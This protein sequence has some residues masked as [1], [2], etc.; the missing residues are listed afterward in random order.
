MREQ[1]IAHS[2]KLRYPLARRVVLCSFLGIGCLASVALG[3]EQ[4]VYPSADGTIVDGGGFGPFDGA[5]D[6]ADWIFN[7]TNYEGAITLARAPSP[8]L[9]RRVVCEYNLN[10]LTVRSPVVA[11]LTI[12]VRGS[13]LFPALTAGMQV[14]SY[15]ADLVEQLND[16]S[17]GPSVLVTEEFILPFQPA[18]LYEIDISSLV[19]AAFANGTK[20]VAFRFQI[21]PDTAPNSNQVFIDAL[22]SDPS[23]KPFIR[24]YGRVKGDFDEDGDVDVEDYALLAP[25][26]TGPDLPTT[27]ACRQCDGDLDG[28]VDLNDVAEF[29]Y[30]LSVFWR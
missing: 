19:D 4:V 23:S 21:D 6:I 1:E 17:V 14:F 29:L 18:T 10:G 3:V 13:G 26:I 16:F 7:E 27:L 25:C 9:E 24:L 30:D 11:T 22:D 28:D 12:R 8:G 15:P 20:K 2:L 5:G